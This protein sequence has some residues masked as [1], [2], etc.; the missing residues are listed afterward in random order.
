MASNNSSNERR[1]DLGK[2]CWN[3]FLGWGISTLLL[4]LLNRNNSSSSSDV[5]QEPSKYTDSNVNQIGSAIPVV[6]GR[7]MIKNPLVS[8]YGDFDYRA[9]TEEYGMHANISWSSILIP[10]L[11][12]IIVILITPNS[13]IVATP[14]G[15]G[16]GEETTQGK[17][18]EMIMM[19][20]FNALLTILTML[21]SNHMGKTTIQKGFKYYLGWQHIICWTG[22]NIGLKRIWMNVYDPDVE[23]ST[24]QGV[25]DNN[26][27]IAWKS[28]NP[29][30]IVA[31]ID[32]EDM[33]GGVDEGGGFVGDIRTY[34][35][36][37]SQPNDSWMIDQM[38]K[39]S[40]IPAELRGLTPK[41]PMFLTAVIPKAYI[42]KQAT[43]PDMW[44]EVVNYPNGLAKQFRG[45]DINW[46]KIGEDSNPA[47]V[48]Y[49]ILKNT[50]WGCSYSAERVDIESLLSL[51]DTAVKESMGVS[52]LINTTNSA[53]DYINKILS[54]ING[55]CYDNPKTG[56]LTFKLIRNDYDEKMLP[57]FS[58]NN[59]STMDFS[60]L[61]W[62]ET[63]NMVTAN[64]TYAD[65]K[66]DTGTIMVSDLANMRITHN[67]V[68]KSIDASYFTTENNAKTY[69]RTQLLSLAYP[70]ASVNFEASRDA[71]N[72]TL[73][74]PIVINWT[75]YGI[76]KQIF[77]VTDIDYG[78]LLDGNIT[79]TAVEDV[80]GFEKT[81][82]TSTGSIGW[83][84]LP[85]VP[86]NVSTFKYL[87]APYEISMSL[88]TYIY[89]YAS[90]PSESTVYWH[91]WRS[92]GGSYVKTM[93]TSQWS[94]VGR[95]NYLL[96][97]YYSDDA[98][99]FTVSPVGYGGSDRLK[100]KQIAINKEPTKYN[101]TS[102]LNLLVIDDEIISYR[103]IVSLLSGDYQIRGVVRGVFD[104][105]P[106]AHNANSYIFFLD[107]KQSITSSIPIA[108][109]QFSNESLEI[110][111]ESIDYKQE[112]D[113]NKVYS[114]NTVRRAE[115]PSIMGNLQFGGDKG[116]ITSFAYN[117]PPT[118]KFSSNILFKFNARNKF[119]NYGIVKQLDSSI[120]P[121][122]TTDIVIHCKCLD[123][124]FDLYYPAI[125]ITG[126]ST[127]LP[128]E[129][130]TFKWSDFCSGM[131][132]KTQVT[133]NVVLDIFTYNR[134]KKLNS[135]A[136]YTKSIIYA[137]P[138]LVGIVNTV[139]DVQI[140]AD[141]LVQ[142]SQIEVPATSVSPKFYLSY[143]DA[144]LIFVGSAY[145][146]TGTVGHGIGGQ[147]GNTWYITN[148][149][150]YVIDGID[151]SGKAVLHKIVIDEYYTFGSKFTTLVSNTTKY[152]RYRGI[153]NGWIPYTP[154]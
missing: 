138:T 57:V 79:V 5:S 126:V 44:F 59:C 29:N 39:S 50:Y 72:L 85:H 70:L 60:R 111:S 31:H 131:L 127:K 110:T 97:E 46:Y 58:T 150:C 136:R 24:E 105:V 113:Y 8:F 56:K 129:N 36:T 109:G 53:G 6:L 65:Q 139:A 61:D 148:N 19:A 86:E 119:N 134:D 153:T 35:G 47:E 125:E 68:E 49:E 1:V 55:V 135:F 17:K 123:V 69:A 112:F 147:D 30:G 83:E 101:E 64:F 41:Y 93:S 73:G 23:E 25:W 33:F 16:T 118:T 90:R 144:A 9:Y 66:Y 15:P 84:D 54:H 4:W 117:Y 132:D 145:S 151:T 102:G 32:D 80:F 140:Y 98:S 100:D 130:I 74:Q 27:H 154:Y 107:N 142:A 63:V 149:E 67:S 14:A 81:D 26:N 88:D 143:Q 11:I 133:N 51:G 115:A 152:Y 104:T 103:E 34:F 42:G 146:S 76:S 120:L 38:S 2:S 91:N 20:V 52:C 37:M 124:E 45:N 95:L 48:I 22:D 96:P 12:T 108:S 71:Y 40:N 89:G 82:Y 10:L 7:A 87:E 128:V 28:E 94:M 13:V 75:P 114:F 92:V 78:S 77:R 122:D 121:E 21:F 106:V 18:N 137:M 62:S 3:A 99:G 116:S 141:T 43:I